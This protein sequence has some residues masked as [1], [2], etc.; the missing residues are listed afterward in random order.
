MISPP[1]KPP[2]SAG[3]PP[4]TP[5][6]YPSDFRGVIRDGAKIC[7]EIFAGAAGRGAFD[8]HIIR[9]LRTFHQI[10]DDG[11]GK[12]RYAQQAVVFQFVRVIGRPMI[13]VVAA[14][15]EAEDWD[16]LRIK[17]GCVR[18]EERIFL[19]HG[20]ESGGDVALLDDPPPCARR[21]NAL[22]EQFVLL[23]PSDHVEIQV[24]DGI[25]K[26]QRRMF[27]EV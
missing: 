10:G 8:L 17:G 12:F 15:E 18:R 1:F 19:E 4:R 13:I 16:A 26:R 6:I 14:G 11:A 23:Q 2:F 9:P 25:G 7:A 3:L 20:V 22:Q 27:R 24:S 5:E 21:A